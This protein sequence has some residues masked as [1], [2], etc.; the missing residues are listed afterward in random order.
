MKVHATQQS[1]KVWEPGEPL[2]ILLWHYKTVWHEPRPRGPCPSKGWSCRFLLK[3]TLLLVQLKKK[4]KKFICH[5]Y[6]FIYLWKVT[7]RCDSFLS[8]KVQKRTTCIFTVTCWDKI[9]L[10]NKNKFFR[11]WHNLRNID[12]ETDLLCCSAPVIESGSK[13][14]PLPT[15]WTTDLRFL[16]LHF[17][18]F[19]HLY[20]Y[21]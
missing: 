5:F 14:G 21:Y 4:R 6:L 1:R 18:K 12:V 19:I 7:Y 20:F 3:L 8:S 13:E 11:M 16:R 10:L 17:L 15:F 2:F 9:P